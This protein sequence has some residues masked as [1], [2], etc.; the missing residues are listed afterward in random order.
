MQSPLSA[1]H[2]LTD[3]PSPQTTSIPEPVEPVERNPLIHS[4]Y[5]I[6]ILINEASPLVSYFSFCE[7]DDD[8]DDA[9]GK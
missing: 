9:C 3:D 5:S 7:S 8:A 6:L 2:S 1:A 4:S